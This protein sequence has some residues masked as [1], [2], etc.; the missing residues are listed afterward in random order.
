[1]V[2]FSFFALVLPGPTQF[3]IHVLPDEHAKEQHT[4]EPAPRAQEPPDV[5]PGPEQTDAVVQKEGSEQLP[6]L[7]REEVSEAAA[8]ELARA[9]DAYVTKAVTEEARDDAAG[10]ELA[11]GVEEIGGSADGGGGGGGGEDGAE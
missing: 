11:V 3:A 5:A 1:M 10:V 4:P 8:E 7:G 9:L 2:P 6:R